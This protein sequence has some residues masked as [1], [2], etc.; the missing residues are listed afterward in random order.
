MGAQALR[1]YLKQMRQN[2]DFEW[3]DEAQLDDTLS[4][5][6]NNAR[7]RQGELYRGKSL[8]SIRYAIQ[9]HITAPP[10]NR[11]NIDII[12]GANFASSRSAFQTAMKEIKVEGKGEV[13]NK[14]PIEPADLRKLYHSMYLDPSTPAGLGNK[15]QFDIRFYFCR[16]AMEGMEKLTKNHFQVVTDATGAKSV[17]QVLGE[18]TKSHRENDQD[19]PE[20]RMVE[21]GGRLCPVANFEK[22]L[23]L[24]HPGCDRL[25][26]SPVDAY[27]PEDTCWYT[28]KPFG[29]SKLRYFLPKLSKLAGL[30]K[31]YTN[32]SIRSTTITL[33]NEAR[34]SPHDI[35]SV[36][37]HKS[38]SSLASY[39]KTSVARRTEMGIKLS[40]QLGILPKPPSTP[41]L[42]KRTCTATSTTATVSR[43]EETVVPA[44]CTAQFGL[45]EL[46][47][48]SSF[49]DDANEPLDP[50]AI[51]NNVRSMFSGCTI[52]TINITIQK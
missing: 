21:T 32:H 52:N 49:F 27:R 11:K 3:F 13:R 10:F 41:S 50:H 30:S 35:C 17:I 7:T 23:S 22:Y 14:P 51:A 31:S 8:Q 46:D 47:I 18:Q 6:Y 29:Y 15:V 19:E 40:N 5:F 24:L 37:R 26:V 9:R 25:F 43:V 33:L 1:A 16:R 38:I 45:A 2:V 34:V 42:P 20:A 4:S 28:R 48:P 39:Q 36:S 12:S 44:T